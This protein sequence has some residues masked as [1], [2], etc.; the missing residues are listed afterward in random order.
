MPQVDVIYTGK[1]CLA[2]VDPTDNDSI[3]SEETD[4]DWQVKII[5]STTNLFV[6]LSSVTTGLI[7]S[8]QS[9]I[10]CSDIIFKLQQ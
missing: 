9:S 2:V 1:N 6:G 7:S 8:F 3:Q 4:C 10:M 5:K